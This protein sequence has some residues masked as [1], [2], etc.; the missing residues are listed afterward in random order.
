MKYITVNFKNFL[1]EGIIKS[2]KGEY[3]NVSKYNIFYDKYPDYLIN[4]HDSALNYW[5]DTLQMFPYEKIELNKDEKL[6]S[7]Q[8][9]VSKTFIDNI[10]EEIYNSSDIILCYDKKGK[11]W[12]L[13][14]HHRLVYDRIHKRNS[15]AYIIPF[16]DV[17]EID[18]MFYNIEQ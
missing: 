15:K 12:L 6:Y 5:E 2:K 14:G 9:I 10:D 1:N 3:L 7:E 8:K 18:N 13:D 17:K 16:D 4:I 11:L